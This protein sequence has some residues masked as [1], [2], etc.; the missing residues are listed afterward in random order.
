M[1]LTDLPDYPTLRQVQQALWGAKE[2]RGAA[3]MVGAGFSRFARLASQDGRTPPLW[4]DFEVEMRKRLHGESLPND[5]L[6]LAEQ[7]STALGRHALDSLIRDLV[8]DHQW[9]PGDMHSRL[10]GLPW[11]DVLTTNWDTLLERTQIDEPD[12][13]YEIVR[14]L[15]DI[16]R[17]RAPRIVKLHGSLPSHEPFI[18]TAEDFRTYPQRFAPFVN[19]AQQ[20]LL[21]NELCLIGFSGD[22]PNFLQWSGWVRDQLGAS[23]RKI[24]LVGVL[25]LSPSRRQVLEHHNISPIDLAPLVEH[26]ERDEKHSR[27][28]T[29]FIDS[30]WEAKPQPSHVWTRHEGHQ[31]A[32][33]K[34]PLPDP[35]AFCLA[36]GQRW[37]EDRDRYPGW[38]VAP[39]Y[40][41]KRL[42]HDTHS[43]FPELWGSLREANA[44]T[45]AMVV[46][47]LIWRHE[48]ALMPIP[49]DA[50]KLA[51]EAL[52]QNSGLTAAQRDEIQIALLRAARR[53]RDWSAFEQL[54]AAIEKSSRMKEGLAYERAL[55]CR[56]EL[57]FAGLAAAVG[58]VA[59]DDPA[60]GIRRA[61]LLCELCQDEKAAQTIFDAW[62][63]IKERRAQD[64]RSIWLLSR[65]A[66][67]AWL[68]KRVHFTMRDNPEFKKM[69]DD[70]F[71]RWPVKYKAANCDPWDETTYFD[72]E[73]GKEFDHRLKEAETVQLRFD[74]G[75]YR[76]QSRTIR[77]VA[78]SAPSFYE[79]FALADHVGLSSSIDHFDVL[80]TRLVRSLEVARITS[81]VAIWA[82]V[83]RLPNGSDGFIDRYFSRVKVAQMPADVA[84]AII[85]RLKQAVDYGRTQF[86]VHNWISRTVKYTELLSRLVVRLSPDEAV[87]M[88]EWAMSLSN[89]KEWEH[90]WL[91][92]P[93]TN[94]LT[95]S[96]EA[97]PPSMRSTLTLPAIQLRLP[98]DASREG[99]EH[100]WPELAFS[101]DR[102]DYSSRDS[103]YAWVNAVASLI[104]TA[105]SYSDLNRTRAIWRLVAMHDAGV[106]T[107][108]EKAS[109]GAALWSQRD[110]VEGLPSHTHLYGHVFLRLPE[111]ETGVSRIAFDHSI[112]RELVAGKLDEFRL[113]SLA[114]SARD[115]E[116][117]LVPAPLT[118]A[119]AKAILA[120]CLEWKPKAYEFPDPFLLSKQQEIE[121][122]IGPCLANAVLPLLSADDIEAD[123]IQKWSDALR[124]SPV[125]SLVQTAAQF[126]R[127]F[128]ARE[129]EAISSIRRAL[130]GRTDIA[131]NGAVVAISH[132][133]ELRGS[134]PAS[135]PHVLASD[136]VSLCV[137]RR[138]P[139]LLM[140]LKCAR[141]LLMAGLIAASDETR[142][143]EA[144]ELLSIETSYEDR[145]P[146]DLP[147]RSLSLVRRECVRLADQLKRAGTSGDAI[148]RWL[149]VYADDPVPEVRFSLEGRLERD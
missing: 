134:E 54:A 59:G 112:V 57:D 35:D 16:A 118:L 122:S 137:T 126:I 139:G 28:M 68:M 114:V 44:D 69:R 119:D 11:A 14:V 128:P 89:D 110:R 90:W 145:D 1:N 121:N 146:R 46:Y 106:L 6:K 49:P 97:V 92:E 3:V 127:I 30:L 100:H 75:T 32:D 23:A 18:F 98:K 124:K 109:F 87:K 84:K 15:S 107:D 142:L 25:N 91:F 31:G 55:R 12:R 140:L 8:S 74:A 64:R 9:T 129:P 81:D 117:N 115:L 108:A 13:T 38:L 70:E 67:A 104:E 83:L 40:E 102:K 136:V 60:W 72:H 47:E 58:A 73:I 123:G 77:F 144:L 135:F 41:R 52:Q 79:I 133:I 111:P 20:V 19:L 48:T 63:D 37:R 65:E 50:V 95:R 141:R 132:L 148:D 93:L 2:V 80:G 96:L 130:A 22:D 26:C 4:S 85:D 88:F 33:R 71:E 51:E 99:I 62:K 82:A 7:Y 45:R 138:E 76:D 34:P 120:R 43:F 149:Q 113:N 116:G 103:S 143:V 21:E 5:P 105:R 17:T 66:W 39:P 36:V 101:F 78:G 27:A 147:S 42:E 10:M 56:D 131:I 53:R 29:I 94:L 125:E 61:A 24:R 86:A